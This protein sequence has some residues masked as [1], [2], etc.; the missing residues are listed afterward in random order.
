MRGYRETEEKR[1]SIVYKVGRVMLLAV[2]LTLL[3]AMAN[4]G[5]NE[6]AKHL[7]VFKLDG[8]RN[9]MEFIRSFPGIADHYA[10]GR[11]FMRMY[12]GRKMAMIWRRGKRNGIL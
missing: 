9:K 1:I 11:L 3:T 6:N 7:P 12:Q 10:K 4:N 5:N 2:T 8:R